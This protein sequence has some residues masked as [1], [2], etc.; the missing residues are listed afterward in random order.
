MKRRRLLGNTRLGIAVL[1]L[2]STV[3]LALLSV[4]MQ[5]YRTVFEPLLRLLLPMAAGRSGGGYLRYN[6]AH[7]EAWALFPLL[8]GAVL[9]VT[10]LVAFITKPATDRRIDDALR[11]RFE[12]SA[13]GAPLER[14]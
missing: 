10:C 1:G 2:T 3:S 5:G 14:E 4:A 6:P 13:R 7:Y 12:Q 11:K 9:F 8:L